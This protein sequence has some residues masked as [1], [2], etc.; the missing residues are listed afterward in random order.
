MCDSVLQRRHYDEVCV[1]PS[2]LCK[3]NLR[4]GDLFLLSW[5]REV[6]CCISLFCHSPSFLGLCGVH[7]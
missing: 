5:A 3:S 1:I 7:C 2:T 4:K 6:V